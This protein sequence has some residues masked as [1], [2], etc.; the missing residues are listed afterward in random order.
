LREFELGCEQA[1]RQLC[2]KLPRE[3]I[4][5][6]VARP[7]LIPGARIRRDHPLSR[8]L[9]SFLVNSFETADSLSPAAGAIIA[10]HAVEL[11]AQA[12]GE[13]RSSSPAPS[14]A[15]REA[16]FVSAGQVIGLSFG[17]PDLGPERIARDLGV[18]TR[19][20]HRLFAER[21]KTV[22]KSIFEERVYHAANLLV[23]P[24]AAHRSVTDIAFACGFNDSAHFSRVFSARM[25]TTPSQWRKCG[26]GHDQLPT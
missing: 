14:D 15:L 3:W 20:L 5:A 12:L 21:G 2:V 4:D 19:F 11:L 22:M 17:D 8:I 1:F 24:A 6:R 10:G 26:S 16:L 25:E 7:D 9:A 23:T 18:S 13:S